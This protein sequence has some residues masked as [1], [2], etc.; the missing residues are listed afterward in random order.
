MAVYLGSFGAADK[1]D[2]RTR[3]EQFTVETSNLVEKSL[4]SPR[5]RQKISEMSAPK[6]AA[7]SLNRS[8][9]PPKSPARSGAQAEPVAFAS[10]S[11][12]S[13][14]LPFCVLCQANLPMGPQ[15]LCGPAPRSFWW[16]CSSRS[17]ERRVGS[18][19]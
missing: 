17:E 3:L 11:T 14:G 12:W 16:Q 19:G 18:K 5:H 9:D 8:R 6:L 2:W 15:N 7:I 10:A 4:R 13:R 1:A